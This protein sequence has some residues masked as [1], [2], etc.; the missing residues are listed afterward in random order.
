LTHE[1][2]NTYFCPVLDDILGSRTETNGEAKRPKWTL[3]SRHKDGLDKEKGV[4]G[5]EKCALGSENVKH[6]RTKFECY[7]VTI[8]SASYRPQQGTIKSKTVGGIRGRE[9][10]C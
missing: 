3:R 4:L 10:S 1:T 9:I 6:L 5:K 8:I 7:K 2:E